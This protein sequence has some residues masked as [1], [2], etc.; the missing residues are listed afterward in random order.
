MGDRFHL[1]Y[2]GISFLSLKNLPEGPLSGSNES[3]TAVSAPSSTERVAPG[4]PISVRTQPRLIVL[5]SIF[6]LNNSVA[7]IFVNE[8]NAVFEIR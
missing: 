7:R 2:H 3:Q 8:F 1:Y 4:P 6:V 5:T